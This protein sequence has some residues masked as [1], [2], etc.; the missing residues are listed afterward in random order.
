ML[1]FQPWK[2]ILILG[3]CLF[4]L[5]TAAP[6]IMPTDARAW[7]TSNLSFVPH[8]PVTLGLDLQG[9]SY[10]LFEAQ[11]EVAVKDRLAT[12]VDD[13]RSGLR[14]ARITFTGLS[15]GP[16][17][18][19]VKIEKPVQLE[20]ART[21]LR[22]LAQPAGASFTG[23]GASDYD[24]V[25]SDAGDARLTITAA[26]REQIRANA[27][28]QSVEI[29]RKRIDPE[30]TKEVTIQPQGERR[31]I[32]QVPGE[33]DPQKIIKLG[34]TAAKLTFH[35]VDDT[36]SREDIEA[37]RLP[38]G[39]RLLKETQGRGQ[40]AVEVPIVI[41]DRAIITGDMLKKA[42]GA[43]DQ[44]TQLPIIQFEFNAVGARR[45]A[46]I[47]KASVGRR[48]A[49]V[50]DEKVITAPYIRTP[51]LGGSGQIEGDF[52]IEEATETA[53][54]LNSGALFV[55]LKE[56]E[57]R[58]VGAELGQDSIEAGQYAA[59]V[60]L[61]LVVGFMVLQYRLFGLFADVALL[62]NLILLL[63]LMTAIGATLTLPGIAAF[64]LTMGMAVDA[65]VLIYE[66]IREEQRN[67]KSILAA[68][69]SGFSRAMTTIID[70][71]LTTLLA[72]LILLMLGS[73]PVRGFAVA[74]SL[75]IL[76]SV[77]TAVYVTRLQVVWWLRGGK[78]RTEL[79][80]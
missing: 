21:F 68:V 37:N 54:L 69:D 40:N 24:V 64:V 8:K 45:F 12:L 52:S 29:L 9:G 38:P 25:V 80:V 50:L 14:K 78:R 42:M 5:I 33:N 56:E 58:T 62:A 36:V 77:F 23:V 44:Q 17:Y 6:N 59:L 27:M 10:V 28:S 15:A 35:M 16:D 55:P 76:T 63:G 72:G 4:G 75:G 7:L 26:G 66:R 60:G 43:F 79:P 18:V 39:T 22:G 1:Q 13:V 3:V 2:V 30:G 73:G 32:V 47:T 48:F 61:L 11:I 19:T 71:N 67:G 53:V 34:S 51:I 20:E 74:L 49:A 57:Q 31:I 46:E 70:S 41:R 65:N